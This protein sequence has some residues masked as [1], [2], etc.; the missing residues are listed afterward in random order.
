MISD[1]HMHTRFSSDSDAPLEEMAEQALKLGMKRIC[2][3]DHYDMEY[4]GGEFS[5]DTASYLKEL[6]ELGERYAGRLEIR[7]GVELGLQ[8]HLGQS[9]RAYTRTHPFDY[10]IGSVHLV[11]GLD[12]YD[13]DQYP[14]SDRE[15]YREY[16]ICTLENIR[17]VTGF[18]AL[19]HLD[20]VVRYG[21]GREKEYSY[22]AYA[23]VIDEILRELI[24]RGIALE[25]NS[26]GLKYGLGFP[27]PHPDV[28]KRYRELGGEL[29]TVGSDAHRPE[30]VG[31]GFSQV[32]EILLD[33]GFQYFAE[34][35]RRKPVFTRL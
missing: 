30:H 29:V 10:V 21:Y 31:Y 23:D 6:E 34:F 4:P 14:G 8:P 27:N 24:C 20:Y 2:V 19:G 18:Q 7:R 3:T 1:C 11:R 9:I 17:S 25:V 12:P 26:G 28:L 5:L 33:C 16:F 13:R 32:R 15:L 35:S 22:R